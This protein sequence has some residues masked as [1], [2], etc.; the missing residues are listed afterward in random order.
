MAKNPIPKV[1]EIYKDRCGEPRYPNG[2]TVEIADILP[3]G[4]IAN[5][6]TD[7]GGLPCLKPR[8]TTMTL[9][10]LRSGYD[11]IKGV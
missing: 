8:S 9:K 10:T 4:V 2:R 6:L 5:V 1:G 3:N 11:L 7:T